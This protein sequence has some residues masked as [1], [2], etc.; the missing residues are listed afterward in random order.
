MLQKTALAA[1]L[2][3]LARAAAAETILVEINGEETPE[4]ISSNQARHLVLMSASASDGDVEGAERA[5]A[6]V[7]TI[8]QD[9]PADMPY[10]A[11]WADQHR[12]YYLGLTTE[13]PTAYRYLSRA[14]RKAV[15]AYVQLEKV[16]MSVSVLAQ[17]TEFTLTGGYCPGGQGGLAPYCHDG[18]SGTRPCDKLCRLADESCTTCGEYG[19]CDTGGGGGGGGDDYPDPELP[20]PNGEMAGSSPT[21]AIYRNLTINDDLVLFATAIT[22][23]SSSC[24]C[25]TSSV[26]ITI[27]APAGTRSSYSGQGD[28]FAQATVRYQLNMADFEVERDVVFGTEHRSFCPI[29]GFTFIAANPSSITK[30]KTFEVRYVWDAEYSHEN[31]YT[32]TDDFYWG[33]Q[34]PSEPCKGACMVP[35]MHRPHDEGLGHAWVR[36]QGIAVKLSWGISCGGKKL[37]SSVKPACIPPLF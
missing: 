19:V 32:K 27:Q 15:R 23:T 22:D 26:G 16:S 2:V 20:P 33:S 24:S 28:A 5:A 12:R 14:G 25:H 35:W 10:L 3:M 11:A 18:C 4:L 8:L 1:V 7:A 6:V 21:G 17:P 36:H 34:A 31:A 37:A 30:T 29:S 9:N 13:G